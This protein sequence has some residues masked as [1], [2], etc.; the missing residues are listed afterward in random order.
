MVGA[1]GIEAASRCAARLSGSALPLSI[2]L[3]NPRLRKANPS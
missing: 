2:Q 1:P 3:A